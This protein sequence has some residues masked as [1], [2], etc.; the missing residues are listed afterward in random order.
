M[1]GQHTIRRKA[2]LVEHLEGIASRFDR[3]HFR[4]EHEQ[5]VIRTFQYGEHRV[6]ELTASVHHQEGIAAL[7]TRPHLVDGHGRD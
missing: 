2:Q 4:R 7:E 3:G 1:Y 6:S 5:D